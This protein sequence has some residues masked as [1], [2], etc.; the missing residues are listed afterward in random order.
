MAREYLATKLA[1]KLRPL[2]MAAAIASAPL[3]F[4]PLVFPSW[5]A[6]PNVGAG[7]VNLALA[8]G[9]FFSGLLQPGFPGV[10]SAL[11]EERRVRAR[12]LPW[13]VRINSWGLPVV[14]RGLQRVGGVVAVGLIATLLF[15]NDV[16]GL[17]GAA[18]AA[19]IAATQIALSVGEWVS[20]RSD[21][22]VR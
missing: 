2:V 15:H 1:L 13:W 21:Q 12:R 14:D 17:L 19:M 6:W 4:L 16:G 5:P 9:I 10:V 3:I 22:Q 8:L 20:T 18:T 11:N 7:V